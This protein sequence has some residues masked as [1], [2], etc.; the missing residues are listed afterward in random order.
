[1][2]FYDNLMPIIGRLL[3]MC[4]DEEGVGVAQVRRK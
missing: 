1:M 4:S 2:E 3:V